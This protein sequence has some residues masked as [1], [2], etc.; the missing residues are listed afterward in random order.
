MIEDKSLVKAWLEAAR[1]KTLMASISPVIVACALAWN[2]GYFDWK[3]ALLCFAVA[4]LAQIASNLANDYFDFAHGADQPDRLGPDRAVAKGWISPKAMLIGTII[5][6]G[7]ACVAGLCLLFYGPWWLIFIG[8]AIAICVFAYSAGPFPLSYHGLGD[9]CVLLFYGIIPVC[10]TYFIMA[11]Q[12][13]LL[14]F[15]LSIAVGYLGVNILI[16][17]NYRDYEQDKAAGKHTTIVIFGRRYGKIS[18][19]LNNVFALAFSLPLFININNKYLV[20]L[21]AFV[22]AL[23]F[24]RT[25]DLYLK[26]GKE[27]NKTLALTSMNV[28]LFAIAVSAILV[29]V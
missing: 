6:L 17:N 11:G 21:Y 25:R 15:L 20:I 19:I 29:S 28:F 12:F 1:P 14:S 9:I 2:E 16:V 10:F 22:M 7:M 26:E 13:S 5:I 4:I 23:C 3:P 8:I 18:Y 24:M 27:L